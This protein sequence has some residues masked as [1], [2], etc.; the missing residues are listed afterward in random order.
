MAK[1]LL[2]KEKGRY[3]TIQ[4]RNLLDIS[5]IAD[6]EDVLTEKLM[7]FLKDKQSVLFIKKTKSNI[8]FQ[9]VMLN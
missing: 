6:V 1:Q 7:D 8:F 3:I 2:L 4:H 9:N 5:K